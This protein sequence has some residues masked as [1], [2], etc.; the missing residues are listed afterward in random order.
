MPPSSDGRRGEQAHGTTPTRLAGVSVGRRRAL[1]AGTSFFKKNCH[2]SCKHAHG[3]ALNRHTHERAKYKRAT[4]VRA[5]R[6][7]WVPPATFGKRSGRA[8][9]PHRAGRAPLPAASDGLD[10]AAWPLVLGY[11]LLAGRC[12]RQLA[13]RGRRRRLGTPLELCSRRSF[14]ARRHSP[15]DSLSTSS[16]LFLPPHVCRV[17]TP[18]VT[19]S[20]SADSQRRC[21]AST[22]W[23][24][25]RAGQKPAGNRGPRPSPRGKAAGRV[26]CFIST[27]CTSPKYEEKHVCH[28]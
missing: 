27:K 18:R 24:A 22:P 1:T 13:P 25:R 15:T 4:A 8:G 3:Q 6:S 21:G 17:R 9:R 10:L 23:P 5:N 11:L 16:R 7:P 12:P 14:S 20:A 28:R 2:S 26:P 19:R